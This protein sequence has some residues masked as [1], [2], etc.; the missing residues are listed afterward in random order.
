M[1]VSVEQWVGS[2]VTT[3]LEL[4]GGSIVDTQSAYTYLF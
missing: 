1:K 3:G 4:N 2:H